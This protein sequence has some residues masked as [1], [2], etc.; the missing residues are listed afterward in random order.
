MKKKEAL[1]YLLGNVRRIMRGKSIPEY[2]PE[3][4]YLE[5][6]ARHLMHIELADVARN[7]RC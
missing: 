1:K 4:I 5:I 2:A 3:Y 7:G 6:V